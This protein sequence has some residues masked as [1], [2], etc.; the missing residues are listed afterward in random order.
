MTMDDVTRETG[1]APQVLT[2]DTS[3]F[4]LWL[5]DRIISIET[6]CA[7]VTEKQKEHETRITALE[8]TIKRAV[9]AVL[10]IAA[11]AG[12]VAGKLFEV[13]RAMLA[14]NP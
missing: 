7:V 12:G 6:H 5:M 14:G 3:A 1:V 4:R 8:T 11:P 13:A 9:L 10:L 2:S